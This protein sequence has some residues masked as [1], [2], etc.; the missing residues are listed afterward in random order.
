MEK[1]D[2]IEKVN[3]ALGKIRPYL[4]ADGGDVSLIEVSDDMVV[5]VKF[6]GACDGCPYSVMTLKAGVEEA[7]RKELPEVK[8]VIA[9]A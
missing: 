2:I 5:K 7:I 3:L 9:E 6:S 1:K 8:D 4:N